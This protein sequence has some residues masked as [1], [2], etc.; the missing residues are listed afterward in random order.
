VSKVHDVRGRVHFDLDGGDEVQG[1]LLGRL[2][3]AGYLVLEYTAH[4]AD[5]E[6][7]FLEITDRAGVLAASGVH[8]VS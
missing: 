4:G 3:G 2:V 6:D 8:A 1:A 7:A 5:L